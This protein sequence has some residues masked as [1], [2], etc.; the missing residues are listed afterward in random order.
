MH[1]FFEFS[2]WKSNVLKFHSHSSSGSYSSPPPSL[3]PPSITYAKGNGGLLPILVFF[4]W[5]KNMRMR[6]TFFEMCKES[7]RRGRNEFRWFASQV[8]SIY[9]RCS[10]FHASQIALSYF[11][12][13]FLSSFFSHTKNVFKILEVVYLPFARINDDWCVMQIRWIEFSGLVIQYEIFFF[14]L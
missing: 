6:R 9:F 2:S 14:L 11:T 8:Y 7:T 13:F 4:F 5:S 1:L 10:S 3:P 12:S